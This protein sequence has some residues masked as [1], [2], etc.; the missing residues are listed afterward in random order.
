MSLELGMAAMVAQ[1]D[2][3]RAVKILDHIQRASVNGDL[4]DFEVRYE[5]ALQMLEVT[6]RLSNFAMRIRG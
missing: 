4:D 2:A 6:E 5:L 3:E 1:H